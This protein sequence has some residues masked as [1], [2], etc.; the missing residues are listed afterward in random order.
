MDEEYSNREGCIVVVI[1]DLAE[2]IALSE[3]TQHLWAQSFLG[4]DNEVGM[5]E[6]N[7]GEG[8]AV[9]EAIVEEKEI[10]LLETVDE[11]ANEFVF[12]STCFVVDEAE[13]CTA[14]QIKE[15]AKL[16]RDRSQSLL[17]LVRAERLPEGLRFGQG[18][19]GLVSS[20]ET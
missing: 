16:D 14:N 12:R 3:S 13:G 15:T 7:L 20:K 19:S 6:E 8:E 1:L 9:V 17:A 18:E 2:I 10:S 4:G 5:T 11:F